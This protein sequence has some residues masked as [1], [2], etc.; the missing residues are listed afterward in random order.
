MCK[1]LK[2][3]HE[4]LLVHR[5]VKATNIMLYGTYFKLTDFGT[6]TDLNVQPES[7]TRSQNP[8]LTED[9]VTRKNLQAKIKPARDILELGLTFSRM[10]S[11]LRWSS[12]TTTKTAPELSPKSDDNELMKFSD[13]FRAIIKRM[14]G[15]ELLTPP[16]AAEILK[17]DDMKAT[18]ERW[19][20]NLRTVYTTTNLEDLEEKF[21]IPK[22]QQEKDEALNL[23]GCSKNP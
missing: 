14:I 2:Y 6:V 7:T 1:A 8:R 13:S 4:K 10:M 12:P 5:D 23:P 19:E 11:G 16:T 17:F 3:L 15:T 21:N 18:A 22:Q 9:E 20:K